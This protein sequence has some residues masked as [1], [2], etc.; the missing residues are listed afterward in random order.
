MTKQN[1][2]RVLAASAAL[3]VAGVIIG[4]WGEQVGLDVWNIDDL[5]RQAA[6]AKD[7]NL[8]LDRERDQSMGRI[9]F[10]MTLA[11]DLVAGR[12]SFA[13]AVD[14]CLAANQDPKVQEMVRR[15]CKGETDAERAAYQMIGYVYALQ[16][17]EAEELARTLECEVVS[18]YWQR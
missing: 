5:Q 1:R 16:T 12:T 14:Q 10:K 13:N 7:R 8:E 4:Q 9:E 6:S 3:T 11:K 2:V 15:V 17:V 18:G